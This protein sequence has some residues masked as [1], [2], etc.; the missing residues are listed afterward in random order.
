MTKEKMI[1]KHNYEIGNNSFIPIDPKM[2][3]SI[4][5][6]IEIKSSGVIDEF[7]PDVIEFEF[8]FQDVNK[9]GIFTMMWIRPNETRS[10]TI[11]ELLS[12][13]PDGIDIDVK[14]VVEYVD[15]V[16]VIISCPYN[17]NID[18]TLFK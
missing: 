4:N 6:K 2:I 1:L 3:I 13:T 18:I 8:T 16:M 15:A 14:Y 7:T 11:K 5:D 17:I 10:G 9:Q 12:I